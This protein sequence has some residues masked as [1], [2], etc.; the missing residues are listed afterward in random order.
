MRGVDM[1]RANSGFDAVTSVSRIVK[2]SCMDPI[3]ALD[4]SSF[5]FTPGAS[6]LVTKLAGQACQRLIQEMSQKVNDVNSRISQGIN[7]AQGRVLSDISGTTGST[8]GGTG[9][10]GPDTTMGPGGT[11]SSPISTVTNAVSHAWD[12]MKNWMT[13]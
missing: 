9:S 1:N 5:G 8:I 13:P 4:M 12:R 3:S 7:D 2:N 11:T 6:A 10:F